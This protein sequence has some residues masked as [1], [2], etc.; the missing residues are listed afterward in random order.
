VRRDFSVGGN[1]SPPFSKKP[2]ANGVTLI[3]GNAIDAEPDYWLLPRYFAI[4]QI[5]VLAGE[6]GAGN[7]ALVA[8]FVAACSNRGIIPDGTN[9]P[10]VKSLIQTGEHSIGSSIARQLELAGANPNQFVYVRGEDKE[11]QSRP[12]EFS[13]DQDVDKVKRK[14]SE[15]NPVDFEEGGLFFVF[16]DEVSNKKGSLKLR[17]VLLRE[18]AETYHLAMVVVVNLSKEY[19]TKISLARNLG[20][21]AFV[22][23]ASMVLVAAKAKSESAESDSSGDDTRCILVCVMS[24]I[25]SVG[26]RFAY[27]I[28]TVVGNRYTSTQAFGEG[29]IDGSVEELLGADEDDNY[30]KPKA[31]D[32][33]AEFLTVLLAN[34]PLPINDILAIAEEAG[35]SEASIRRVKPKLPIH[36]RPEMGPDG[37]MHSVWHWI[38]ASNQSGQPGVPGFNSPPHPGK[39][40]YAP[41]GQATQ[42]ANPVPTGFPVAHETNFANPAQVE[43]PA[44]VAQAEQ[45]AHVEQAAQAEQVAGENGGTIADDENWAKQALAKVEAIKARSDSKAN[46]GKAIPTAVDDS[47]IIGAGPEAEA[48]AEANEDAAYDADFNAVYAAAYPAASTA[49]YATADKAVAMDVARKATAYVVFSKQ[50]AAEDAIQSAV[51]NAWQDCENCHDEE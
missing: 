12:L 24:K 19:N 44:Q 33:A 27:S 51:H 38:P 30:K 7:D 31:T 11:E 20:S 16:M 3:Y 17:L 14:L 36:D 29:P 21:P 47:G 50:F 41:F 43:N 23:E 26:G 13:K 48:K 34:G 39:G 37:K 18:I 10:V 22:S 6:F 1:G 28:R 35:I 25:G 2:I 4:G 46:E 9:A 42:Y 15:I 32:R 8:M 5:T 49:L 40:F 45:A